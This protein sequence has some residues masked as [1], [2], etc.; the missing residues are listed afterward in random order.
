MADVRY[1]YA[2]YL[3]LMGRKEEAIY[4]HEL[5][6]KLDP[7]MA[8]NIAWLGWL[9]AFYGMY[10]KAEE[11]AQI[12]LDIDPN[13]AIGIMA[14]GFYFEK[15]GKYDQAL[16]MYKKLYSLYPYQIGP[17]GFI[18]ANMGNTNEAFKIINEIGQWPDSPWK[19]WNLVMM[20]ASLGDAEKAFEWV[21]Y[22]PTHAYIP[23]IRVIPVFDQFH[24]HPKFQRLIAEM[25][26]PPA[27]E[28]ILV[29]N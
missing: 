6:V 10:N 23:W 21:Q 22:K 20:Y 1:H 12:A 8:K 17:L 18:N 5:S 24:N 13:H 26:L 28:A 25:H 27:K 15:Q 2:W 9:Y 14:M 3:L 16:E 29:K 19:A 11:Q 7:L 4:E